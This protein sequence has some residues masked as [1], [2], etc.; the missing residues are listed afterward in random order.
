[1]LESGDMYHHELS[2][3]FSVLQNWSARSNC[4]K[5]RVST[6]INW[7]LTPLVASS[8]PRHKIVK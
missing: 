7:S 3:G 1:M 2:L 6:K 4:T 5:K 8:R